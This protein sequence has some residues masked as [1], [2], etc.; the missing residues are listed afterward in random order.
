MGNNKPAIEVQR[1]TKRFGR[2]TAVDDITLSIP[3]GCVCG[4]LGP[5]GAGKTTTIKMLM[6]LLP[7]TAGGMCVVGL[8]PQRQSLQLRQRIGYVPEHHH[9]YKWMTIG[10]VFRFVGGIYR[11]WSDAECMRIRTILGLPMDRKVKQLSHGELAKLAL[12]VALSHNPELLI[13]DEPTT[14]LDPLIRQEF[15]DAIVHLL[16]KEGRTVLFSTHILSDVDRVADRM[17]VLKEGRVL[18]QGSIDELRGRYS[19]VSLLF[20]EPPPA[21]MTIPGAI[22]VHRGLREWVAIF[23]A[24]DAGRLAAL[25]T[26]LGASDCM[27]HPMSVEDIFL[28]LFNHRPHAAVSSEK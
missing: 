3:R 23:E 17:I 20:A 5:N 13:L 15:L 24:M 10:Q 7:P 2:K 8:D 19:K 21:E 25:R 22:R 9:I 11:N 26:S 16:H 1:L 6:G 4:L 14:G 27:V 18:A 12:C 28:E